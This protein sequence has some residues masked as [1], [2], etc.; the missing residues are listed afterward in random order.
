VIANP[1]YIGESSN[2]AIFRQVKN[3]SLG[4]RFAQGKM[5]YFYYFFHLAIDLASD[6]GVISFIT[7]NYFPTATSA[8][9]LRQEFRS[10]TN[11]LKL[12]NFNELKIFKSAVGQHNLITLLAKG[13]PDPDRLVQ[14]CVTDRKGDADSAVL[15]QILDW[16]DPETS[17]FEI[18]QR[19][20]YKGERFDIVLKGSRDLDKVLDKI[21]QNGVALKSITS[22]TQGIQ[23]GANDVF[24]F[25]ST[26]PELS[27]DSDLIQNFIKP[28]Y[29]NSDIVR[30]GSKASNKKLLYIPN[31]LKLEQHP[32]L[33]RYLEPH[34]KQLASRAQIVRSHQPW[35]QLLWPRDPETF[36]DGPKI[37]APYRSKANA[38]FYTENEFYGSTDTYFVLGHDSLSLKSVLACL[39]SSVGLV[40]FKN[41][42][43]VKGEVLD[44]TGDNLDLFPI[45]VNSFTPL[46]SEKLE[47]LVDEIQLLVANSLHLET[48]IQSIEYQEIYSQ[49]DQIVLDCYGL[50]S[51]EK[52]TLLSEFSELAKGL[53]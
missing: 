26:P 22:V 46:V 43:K 7:T 53:N 10:K 44:L 31:G 47:N 30:Y 41:M 27:G 2:K 16:V 33:L 11:V 9:L 6:T 49:I 5:D 14:T 25:E 45:P 13:T 42:G 40:W 48:K 17:Y 34:K 19:D 1:P 29:K 18:P 4:K 35:H 15:N 36:V 23:T 37:V 24:V 8:I 39:N 32:N 38:F 50:D 12:V 52:E 3:S 28:L 21:A 20:L 51:S